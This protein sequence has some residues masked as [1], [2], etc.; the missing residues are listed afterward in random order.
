M[1]FGPEEAS[2]TPKG[3]GSRFSG[4][5]GSGRRRYSGQ[6]RPGSY[7]G[8]GQPAYSRHHKRDAGN[9]AATHASGTPRR[10]AAEQETAAFGVV[11]AKPE[12]RRKPVRRAATRPRP[13]RCRQTAASRHETRSG[14]SSAPQPRRRPV[15]ESRKKPKSL[16]ILPSSAERN[17]NAR[18]DFVLRIYF[19]ILAEGDRPYSGTAGRSLVS[20]PGFIRRNP[21]IQPAQAGVAVI[22]PPYQPNSFKLCSDLQNFC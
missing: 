13:Y 22:H 21:K 15:R 5:G 6:G 10:N 7:R 11:S 12:R 17:G 2:N 19:L 9:P 18:F 14:R 20:S 8:E 1:K 3:G 16:R 4:K